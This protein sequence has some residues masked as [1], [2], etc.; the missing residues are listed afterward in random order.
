[1][2][3]LKANLLYAINNSNLSIE[4]AYYVTKDVFRE[5]ED[6]Y[7]QYLIE[8]QKRR[9]AAAQE[10]QAQAE[11]AQNGQPQEPTVEE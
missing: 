6:A 3:Q 9:A 8:E 4:A 11:E 2:E 5:L 10:A 1:M 7:R